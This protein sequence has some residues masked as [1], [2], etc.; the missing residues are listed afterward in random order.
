[1][2]GIEHWKYDERLEYLGLTRLQRRRIRSDLV[3]T[4]KIM[5]GKYDISCDLCFKLDVGGRRGHDLKLF[6]RRFRLDIRKVA[7]SN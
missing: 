1:M 5:N 2:Q 3:E 4:F 6:K 7:F